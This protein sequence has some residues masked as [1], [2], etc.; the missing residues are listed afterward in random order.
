MLSQPFSDWW[1]C[2]RPQERQTLSL[3]APLWFVNPTY[4]HRDVYLA[5]ITATGENSSIKMLEWFEAHYGLEHQMIPCGEDCVIDAEVFVGDF[6]PELY[7]F[8]QTDKFI[9]AKPCTL[10]TFPL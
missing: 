5:I 8:S 2:L 1:C 6:W 9:C 10:L 7:L 4:V 3:L